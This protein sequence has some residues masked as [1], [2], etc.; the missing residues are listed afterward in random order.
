MEYVRQ[1]L[2][3]KFT[4]N[5]K[6]NLTSDVAEVSRSYK[7]QTIF[8]SADILNVVDV[9]EVILFS[10]SWNFIPCT[11]CTAFFT[12]SPRYSLTS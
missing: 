1:W 2:L 12:V 3:L 10:L 9:A 7:L 5:T 11:C 6:Q 8:K 4:D